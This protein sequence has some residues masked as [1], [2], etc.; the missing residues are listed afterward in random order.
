MFICNFGQYIIDKIITTDSSKSHNTVQSMYL[1]KF[2]Q[3]SWQFLPTVLVLCSIILQT[4]Y[5][6]NY[7]G[8][9]GLSHSFHKGKYS[10]DYT[11]SAKWSISVTKMSGAYVCIVKGLEK[12]HFSLI[13]IYIVRIFTFHCS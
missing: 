8:I 2:C 12:L 4:Y 6:H 11:S 13:V 7:A 9:I 1:Y 5:A 10:K 3:L